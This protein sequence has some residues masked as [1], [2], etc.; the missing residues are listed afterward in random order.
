MQLIGLDFKTFLVQRVQIGNVQVSLQLHKY[1]CIYTLLKIGYIKISWSFPKLRYNHR[2]L[3]FI[4][5]IYL[6]ILLYIDLVKVNQ[7]V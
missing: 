3:F 6:K 4:S 2:A 1:A 7:S 5:C